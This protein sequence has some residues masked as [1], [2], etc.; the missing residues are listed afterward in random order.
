MIVNKQLFTHEKMSEKL[1]KI[2]DTMVAQVPQPVSLKLPKLQ[3][4][5]KDDKPL[6]I[7]LPKIKRV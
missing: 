6:K 3:K 4:V 1:C 7:S 5:D 2:V